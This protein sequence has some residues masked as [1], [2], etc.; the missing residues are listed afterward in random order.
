MYSPPTQPNKHPA[1]HPRLTALKDLLQ[2]GKSMLHKISIFFLKESNDLV[3]LFPLFNKMKNI[4]SEKG[5]QE[6]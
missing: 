4:I 1:V 2:L 3:I 5:S 6:E